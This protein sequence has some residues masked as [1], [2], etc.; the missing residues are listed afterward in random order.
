MNNAGTRE[1]E[2]GG[3]HEAWV[4]PEVP[5][6]ESAI[7]CIQEKLSPPSPRPRTHPL[8]RGKGRAH[9]TQTLAAV[10]QGVLSSVL[11][12]TQSSKSA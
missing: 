11:R 7:L 10:L 1:R 8:E 2:G 9:T 3:S 5:R 4:T 12:V 6:A